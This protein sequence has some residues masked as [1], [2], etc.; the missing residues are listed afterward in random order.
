MVLVLAASAATGAA[1]GS[2]PNVTIVW[3]TQDLVI[4]STKSLCYRIDCANLLLVGPALLAFDARH[5]W[6]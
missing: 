5:Q 1:P 6:L 3:G 2:L 4:E